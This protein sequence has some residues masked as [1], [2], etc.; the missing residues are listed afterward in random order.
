MKKQLIIICILA[1]S[2]SA[3][4]KILDKQPIDFLSPENYYNTEGQLNTA[5]NAIYTTL[6]STGTYANNMLGRMGLDA[7]EGFNNYTLD[8][9]SAGD[10]NVPTTDTKI[11]AYW[12]ALYQGIN[13]ANLLLQNVQKP[14]MDEAKRDNIRGQAL[15]LRAYYYLMLVTRFGDV[16]LILQTATS[17]EAEQVQRPRT[18]ALQ[19]YQQIFE[20]MKEAAPLV[21]DAAS[22]NGGGRISKSTVWGM[23][24]RVCL[25]MAG[26]PIND[27]SKY[28]EAKLWAK[29]V[30]DLG[31]HELNPSFQQVFINYAADIYDIRESIW[32]V[33]F[34]GNGTGLYTTNGGMVGRNNGIGNTQDPNV[35]YAVGVLHT[36][37]WLYNLYSSTDLRKDWVIAPFRY[38][39]N[40]A[41]VSDWSSSQIIDRYCGKYRRIYEVVIP[42][43][44]A[45]TPINYPLLRYADVLLMFAEADNEVSGGPT[46]EAYEAINQVR[47]RGAGL[48]VNMP[49][50]SVDLSGLDQV[51]F[52]EELQDERSRELAFENLRKNDLVRW[53]IFLPRMQYALSQVAGSTTTIGRWADTYFRNAS[54]RD[55]L[56]PIPAYEMTVNKELVQNPGW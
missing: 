12:T 45:R 27:Q 1:G 38:T 17:P 21:A 4:N 37:V 33:E 19:V 50:P 2:F 56:W 47:R 24:A 49:D 23:L 28:A 8:I 29:K 16:P 32:E 10:Y 40:P 11:L 35:G 5:L 30:I 3:C 34:W 52:F 41:T 20:D 48:P 6:G 31:F 18:P 43:N 53:N 54:E 44:T 13:R 25:Y 39:G 46:A 22:L 26:N 51:S 42:R 55:V 15:F 14:E 36:S 7:D 9:A